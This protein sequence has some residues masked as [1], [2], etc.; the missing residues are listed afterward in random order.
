MTTSPSPVKRALSP[1]TNAT[2]LAS[3]IAAIYAAVVLIINVVQHHAAF[4][5]EVI[6][7][8]ISAAAFLYARFRVTPLADPKDAVGNKLV[9]L[10]TIPVP[11]NVVPVPPTQAPIPNP[12][13]VHDV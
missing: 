2:G 11:S 10:T 6:V 9:P 7:A 4:N 5:P 8:A 13:E 1:A 12:D 3:A